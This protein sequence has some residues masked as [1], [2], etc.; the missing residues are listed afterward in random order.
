MKFVVEERELAELLYMLPPGSWNPK[1]SSLGHRTMITLVTPDSRECGPGAMFVAISGTRLDG[2]SYIASAL[3]A[4]AACVVAETEHPEVQDV[5]VVVVPSCREFLSLVSQAFFNFPARG[6]KMIGITGTSGK[7]S[8]AYLIRRLL[9][10]LD[11]ACV[12]IGTTGYIMPNGEFFPPDALPA[13]T[14]EAFALNWYLDHAVHLGAQVAVVEV[15][16]FA[17]AFDR[18]HGMRFDC[19]VFTNFS[20]DHIGYHGT[21]DAY[22]AAKLRLFTSL[23]ES[24]VAV[25]NVDDASFA[26]FR[27]AAGRSHVRTF[28]LEQAADLRG[29]HV[30]SAVGRTAFQVVARGGVTFDVDL[31]IGPAFQASNCLAA[32]SSVHAIEP[33]CDL[34]KAIQSLAAPLYV[35]GRYERIDC[36]QPFEVIVDYAHT[37][38]EFS[39]LFSAVRPTVRGDLLAVFGSVGADDR[40]KRPIMARLAEDA[41]RWSF[42][43]VED[44]RHEDA[45]IAVRDIESGFTTDHFTVIEDRRQAIRSAIAMARPGDMVL[46]LGRGHETIMYYEHEDVVFDDRE[47]ARLA[48][49]DHGYVCGADG[50]QSQEERR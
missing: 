35:P 32:I 8:T 41:C 26:S 34:G 27:D 19:G 22:L 21:M 45:S 18:V 31:S 36:G 13:T 38:E 30:V 48:L 1:R 37:P 10:G 14:P 15:S 23:D 25:L 50:R 43:T 20:Q 17:L 44:P 16:S 11:I 3:C 46:V 49:R 42:V 39:A 29:D 47:E 6:M 2:A 9:Q 12:M 7:T 28:S 40:E 24:S 4:G 33:T 5:P